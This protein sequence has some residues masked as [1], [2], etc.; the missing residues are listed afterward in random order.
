MKAQKK[1][2][3][4]SDMQSETKKSKL[5]IDLKN[6]KQQ[7]EPAKPFRQ[8]GPK[9]SKKRKKVVFQEQTKSSM[10]STQSQQD[11]AKAS[12]DSNTGNVSGLVNEIGDFLCVFFDVFD[13]HPFIAIIIAT[14]L[15]IG[16]TKVV[17]SIVVY[18][19]LFFSVIALVKVAYSKMRNSKKEEG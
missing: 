14:L 16:A 15:L 13:E 1:Q 6:A 7:A 5:Q 11:E 8:A 4:Q 12:C 2:P 18:A 19:I 17:G 9:K 10:N 3:K